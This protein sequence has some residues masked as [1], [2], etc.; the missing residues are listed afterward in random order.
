MCRE[1]I[2]KNGIVGKD[3]KIIANFYWNQSEVLRVDGEHTE[4]VEI[5][6]GCTG[7]Y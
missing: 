3:F 1:Q 5:L 7:E 2:K 6:R 4:Q